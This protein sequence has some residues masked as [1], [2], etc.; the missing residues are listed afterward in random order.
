MIETKDKI[1]RG[2][3]RD[4]ELE[5]KWRKEIK[6]RLMG[7]GEWRSDREHENECNVVTQRGTSGEGNEKGGLS[8]IKG[9]V[10]PLLTRVSKNSGQKLTMVKPYPSWFTQVKKSKNQLNEMH[11][12]DNNYQSSAPLTN[13]PILTH[14]VR[15]LTR[16]P[17]VAE[18]SSNLDLIGW[19][20]IISVE[21]HAGK[22]ISQC[23][24]N[25]TQ[26]ANDV[27]PHTC[28]REIQGVG[29]IIPNSISQLHTVVYVV[30]AL[31]LPLK[32]V[33]QIEVGFEVRIYRQFLAKLRDSYVPSF[34]L[35]TLLYP[36]RTS[37]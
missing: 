15:R 6:L 25:D 31:R 10:A 23:V 29:N 22:H 1:E 11:D 27:S 34:Y 26:T 14:P 8:F 20:Q 16:L 3:T 36:A 30:F 2:C 4:W 7:N 33:N 9:W 12:E 28:T 18:I 5:N 19:E 13:L 35:F 17:L 32:I 37:M 21:M 24:P